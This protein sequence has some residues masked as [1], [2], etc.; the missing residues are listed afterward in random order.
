MM[1]RLLTR[2]VPRATLPALLLAAVP[3][4]VMGAGEPPFRLAIPVNIMAAVNEND[5]R[6]A[7]KVWASSVERQLGM[8]IDLERG[9]LLTS[10]QLLQAVRRGEVEGFAATVLDYLQVAEY[11][12]PSL[13]VLDEVY[14]T[15]GEEYII[16]A[17]EESGLRSFR[18][19]RGRRLTIY[20][21]PT[22]CLA[23]AWLQILVSE[24]GGGKVEG[25]FSAVTQNASLSRGVILP[26]FF[27]QT[28][29]C[30]VTRRQYGTMC[31]LNPQ[32]RTRLRVIETSPKLVPVVMA[33]QKDGPPDRRRRF[34]HALLTLPD[35]PVGQQLVALFQGGHLLLRDRTSLAATIELVKAAEQIRDR[36]ASGR[37]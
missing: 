14:A 1:R 29:G 25:F 2:A 30:M 35:S 13:L 9:T 28:D 34:A 19:L 21:N 6:A 11:A 7:L 20:G 10:E 33:F 36:E 5:A 27:R 31:E 22:M 26:V 12:D 17:H 15:R 24:S 23:P 8:G 37:R 4:V 3:T 32:L 16:L 18:D